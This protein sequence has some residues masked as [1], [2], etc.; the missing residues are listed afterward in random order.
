LVSE[1]YKWVVAGYAVV[2]AF[3]FVFVEG[4]GKRTL[5]A[6]L[7]RYEILLAGEL[8][9]P[10]F[11]G[12]LHTSSPIGIGLQSV[13]ASV[14]GSASLKLALDGCEQANAVMKKYAAAIRIAFFMLRKFKD[15][16][17]VSSLHL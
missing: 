4:V 7:A 2:D 1:L 15:F 12:F 13:F 11:V 5:G 6:F 17:K 16:S 8:L 9:F 14:A 3:V 10:F